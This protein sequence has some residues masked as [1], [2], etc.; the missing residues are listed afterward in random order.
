[1]KPEPTTPS[2]RICRGDGRA[3]AN[4]VVLLERG[5]G[6]E[7]LDQLSGHV[8]HR[9]LTERPVLLGQPRRNSLLQPDPDGLEGGKRRWIVTAGLLQQLL[10]GTA[11]DQLT[12]CCRAVE[13]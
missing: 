12:P 13:D 5:C 3:G 4:A 10:T 2:R 8:S 11:V 7:D 6:K 9:K 1:M